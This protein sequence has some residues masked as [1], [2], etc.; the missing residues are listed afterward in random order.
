MSGKILLSSNGYVQIKE[1]VK[2]PKL[3]NFQDE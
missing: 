2:K 3:K 1:K